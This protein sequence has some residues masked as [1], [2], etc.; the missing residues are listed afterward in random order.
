MSADY[1]GMLRVVQG[2]LTIGSDRQALIDAAA[3]RSGK[4]DVLLNVLG[5]YPEKTLDEI[6]LETWRSIL[7]STC[8]TTFDM[9][10]RARPFLARA[11]RARVINIGDSGADRIEARVLATP[12]HVSKVGV[13]ILTRSYAK[14][15]GPEGTTVNLVSPGFLDNSVGEAGPVP[16]GRLGTFADIWGAVRYLLSPEADYVSGTNLVV[17]G[18]WNL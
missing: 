14:L 1:P 17:S 12:Y 7:E 10:R 6:D 18:A 5:L 3:A 11:H 15:L 13:H 9:T 4:V 2:D 16:L 8:T